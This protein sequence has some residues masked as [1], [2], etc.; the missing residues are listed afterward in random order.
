MLNIKNIEALEVDNVKSK[1]YD[2]MVKIPE[3]T[4]KMMAR[5]P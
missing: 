4:F 3:G 1:S 2:E 5:R